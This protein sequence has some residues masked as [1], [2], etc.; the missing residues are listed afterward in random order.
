MIELGVRYSRMLSN[1]AYSCFHQ[2][3]VS[4]SFRFGVEVR[5]VNPAYSS[6]IGLTKF[7]SLY[8]LYSDRAIG[9]IGTK[10]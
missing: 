8:G 2:M 6:L 10:S 1:F 5:F 9:S 3:L 4:R 7:M